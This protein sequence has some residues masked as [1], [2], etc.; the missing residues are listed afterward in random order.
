VGFKVLDSSAASTVYIDDIRVLEKNHK[1]YEMRRERVKYTFAPGMRRADIELGPQP[2][3]SY[4]WIQAT[5]K[6]AET[7]DNAAEIR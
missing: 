5:I 4:E 1:H 2:K 3:R 6:I 7:A